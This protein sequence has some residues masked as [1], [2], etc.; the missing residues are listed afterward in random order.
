[1]LTLK[2]EDIHV[3]KDWQIND[4]VLFRIYVAIN[5]AIKLKTFLS[6]NLQHEK[7][8]VIRWHRC[9]NIC[10]QSLDPNHKGTLT[11]HVS[12]EVEI[13]AEQIKFAKGAT[14]TI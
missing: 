2:E 4:V 12:F 8:E 6:Q 5:V 3:G 7:H 10:P 11:E 1:M 9:N 14:R 13:N